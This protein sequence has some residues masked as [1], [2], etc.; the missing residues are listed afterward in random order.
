VHAFYG[1]DL[2][3]STNDEF[4]QHQRAQAEYLAQLNAEQNAAASQSADAATNAF[5][6][7]DQVRPEK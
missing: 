7:I 6:G 3:S 5:F 1:A 2:P 4:S